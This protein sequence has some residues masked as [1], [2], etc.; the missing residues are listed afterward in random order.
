MA[1]T[2]LS[3]PLF[4]DIILPFLLVFTVL[5]AILQKSE[6]LGKG[7]K[8]VDAIVSLV[9]GLIVIS[10]GQATDVIV[11]L[12]PFLAVSLV[13][14]LVFMILFGSVF[15]AGEFKIGC[16]MKTAF[17]IIIAIAVVV[18]V[19]VVT[20]AWGWLKDLFSGGST[21]LITNIV[22]IVL[23]VVAVAVVIGFS[24]KAKED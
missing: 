19:A 10:F 22:F 12:M 7:K 1:E 5:F 15:K 2:I 21:A 6:I 11:N 23:V 3:S 4:L 14:I 18:A 16:G 20:G 24:G 17:G 9:V 13:V 8:Q